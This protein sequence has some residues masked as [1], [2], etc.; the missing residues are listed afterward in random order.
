M[1]NCLQSNT[2]S[3]N[4]PPIWIVHDI[5][6]QLND[7]GSWTLVHKDTLVLI[8]AYAIIF[9]FFLLPLILFIL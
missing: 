8:H 1:F 5:L 6:L 3:D 7:L 9:L 4:T 2:Q